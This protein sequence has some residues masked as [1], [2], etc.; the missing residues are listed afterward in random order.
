[1]A[2]ARQKLKALE[3]RHEQLRRDVKVLTRP[4]WYANLSEKVIARAV[5]TLLR[6]I[7]YKDQQGSD[8]SS[9]ERRKEA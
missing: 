5:R 6:D 8:R 7:L 3:A 9:Y 2:T 4:K 1:M